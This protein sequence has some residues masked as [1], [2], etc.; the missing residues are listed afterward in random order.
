MRKI[1]C[2]YLDTL[3]YN[4]PNTI[5]IGAT[6]LLFI[7]ALFVMIF[8]KRDKFRNVFR[9][10]LL[11]YVFQ[12]YSTTVFYRR[13]NKDVKY[14]YSL[15]WSYDKPEL[16]AENIL[17]VI[18]FIPIGLLIGLGFTKIKWWQVMVVGLSISMLI[19]FLQL[20]LKRG[21]SELDDVMHN[22][23]GCMIGYGICLLIK[24]G[25]KRCIVRVKNEAN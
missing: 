18:V 22:T 20:I 23:L 4:V 10:F 3:Y 21:F 13:V 6:I 16:I 5:S 11:F 2:D 17:N 12:L 1:L 7:G 24:T 8:C 9:L 25:Y 19:E 15:F 14:N